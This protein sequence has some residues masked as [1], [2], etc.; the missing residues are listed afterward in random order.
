[1]GRST[2]TTGTITD[3][4]QIHIKPI[5]VFCPAIRIASLISFV[6]L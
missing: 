5:A 3:L 2:P 6:V 1:M 4:W